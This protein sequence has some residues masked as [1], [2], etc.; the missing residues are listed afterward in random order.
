V[1]GKLSASS[2]SRKTFVSTPI[3]KPVPKIIDGSPYLNKIEALNEVEWMRKNKTPLRGL[4]VVSIENE[5]VETH[6][7]KSV[8]F[9]TQRLAYSQAKNFLQKQMVGKWQWVEFKL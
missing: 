5:S 1:D 2:Q 9:K 3:T 6:Y 4:D 7:E 8:W